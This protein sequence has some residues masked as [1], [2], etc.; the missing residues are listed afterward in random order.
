MASAVDV[1]QAVLER[2]LILLMAPAKNLIVG[3][4]IVDG[5]ELFNAKQTFVF[6]FTAPS[7]PQKLTLQLRAINMNF[8]SCGSQI[9]TNLDVVVPDE[10]A[11][12]DIPFTEHEEDA[13]SVRLLFDII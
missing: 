1:D 5:S 8:A 2:W 10:I 3:G 4:C 11:E 12:G 9:S 6:K 13:E 7:K